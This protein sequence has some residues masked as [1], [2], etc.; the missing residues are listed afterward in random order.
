MS[1]PDAVTFADLALREELQHALEVLGYEEPT[2]VQREAVPPLLA[3]RDV[4]GVAATG[5]G[6]TAAFALPLLNGLAPLPERPGTPTALVLTPTRELAVQ[7]SEA[8]YKYGRGLGARVLPVYGGTP[9]GQQLRSLSRGVDVVVATPGRAVDLLGR[10]ALDF[11]ALRTVVLDE[12][13]EMLDMGFSED[14]E[15]LL[16]ATPEGRQTVLFSATM[17]SRTAALA[18]RHLRE[19][20]QVRIQN[21]PVA[22]GEVPRVRQVA[23]LV[24]RAH[25]TAALGRVLDME[26][27]TSA[28]VFCRTRE[29]V[30]TVTESLNGRGYRAEAL[31][32]GM[33]QDQRDRV[34]G[35]LRSGTA[36]LLVATDVAARGLDVEHLTHVVNYDVPSAPESYVHRIGR[37]GRAGREGVAITL[38]D[39]REH[40]MLKTIERVT[41]RRITVETLPTV[42]D[43]HARR[44]ELTR[45][46]LRESLLTDDLDRFR[47]VVEV[48]SDEFDVVQVALAA[49]KLAH[50]AAAGGDGDEPDIPQERPA[51]GGPARRGTPPERGR[52]QGGRSAGG[53]MTRLFVGAGRAAGVRPQDL[54]GAIAGE[55]S[56]TG[57]DVGAIEITERFSLV[58]VPTDRA[59]E[60]IQGLR[61]ATL[62]GRR[63]TVRRERYQSGPGGRNPGRNSGGDPRGN[64]GGNHDD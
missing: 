57:R 40:R 5:T 51:T 31:H 54:V 45:A 30:D 16:G 59:E 48:L 43:L 34:M 52:E 13:D 49:V 3:G 55:S 19:P 17:P 33:S 50:E 63:P 38:S 21:A 11:G 12:A 61:G 42:A 60:V 37:V 27:P 15:A 62:R 36:D 44:L 25:K 64:S 14:I 46:A 8:L 24:P 35:R 58:D 1:T 32:G 10:G 9:I 2:P 41:G 4:L 29:E 7:V 20:V 18:R 6:K 39:S 26:S 23:Y 56:L 47:T 53:A 22:A 28:L